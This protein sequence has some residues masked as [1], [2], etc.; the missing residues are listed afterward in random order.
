MSRMWN[1]A[2]S[3]GGV[4]ALAALC[5]PEERRRACRFC[6]IGPKWPPAPPSDD[7]G[8]SVVHPSSYTRKDRRRAQTQTRSGSASA[9]RAALPALP[10]PRPGLPIGP[11]D[12]RGRRTLGAAL[13]PDRTGDR[14]EPCWAARCCRADLSSGNRQLACPGPRQLRCGSAG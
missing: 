14:G 5:Q 12:R 7:W 2:V 10:S 13:P 11:G 8:S 6:A 9:K 4:V 3:S 1:S